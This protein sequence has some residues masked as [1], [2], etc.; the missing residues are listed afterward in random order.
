MSSLWRQAGSLPEAEVP[1]TSL[2]PPTAMPHSTTSRPHC[3]ACTDGQA[4]VCINVPLY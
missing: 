4:P 1:L 3:L 2:H